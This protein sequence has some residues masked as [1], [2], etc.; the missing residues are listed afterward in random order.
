M[1]LNWARYDDNIRFVKT[2]LLPLL[3][4]ERSQMADKHGGDW[5]VVVVVVVVIVSERTTADDMCDVCD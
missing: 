1:F 5:Q 3:N 2:E 4:A